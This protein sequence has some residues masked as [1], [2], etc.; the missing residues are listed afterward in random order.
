MGAF[1]KQKAPPTPDYTALATQ[2]GQENQAAATKNWL[3][4]NSTISTPY[5]TRRIVADPNEPSGYRTEETLN[6]A[7]QARLDQQRKI[8]SGVLDLAPTALGY[9]Q[10]VIGKPLDPS[11]LPNAVSGVDTS[12]MAKGFERGGPITTGLDFS[13]APKVDTGVNTRNAVQ[14]SILDQFNRFMQPQQTQALDALKNEIANKGGV[15]TGVAG[16]RAIGNLLKQ[17][18]D[19]RANAGWTAIQKAGDAAQQQ[20]QMD[21]LTRQQAVGETAQQGEFAN[22]A[23]QQGFGQ[24]KALADFYNTATQQDIANAFSNANLA[25]SARGAGLQELMNLRQAPLNELMALLGGTQVAPTQFNQ[26]S[27]VNWA[28]ANLYGAGKDQYAADVANTNAANARAAGL[29]SGLFSL[30]GAGMGGG[31]GTALGK[32]VFG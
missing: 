13:G 21:L 27:G 22:A 32:K 26:G 29:T 7:D 28:P 4:N 23:Q 18:A 20:H 25:N 30:A 14:Q 5:G 2:Q 10:N 3:L 17:Q 24:N 6:P 15:T 19:E 12:G 8:E 1:K 31:F 11:S 9:L 16:Q